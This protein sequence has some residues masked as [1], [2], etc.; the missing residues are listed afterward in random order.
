MTKNGMIWLEI[1]KTLS[2]CMEKAL[3]EIR[4]AFEEDTEE[5]AGEKAE[6]LAQRQEH[7]LVMIMQWRQIFPDDSG[8]WWLQVRGTALLAET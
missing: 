7:S 6:E 5:A 2:P 4:T 8:I 3:E 1:Q